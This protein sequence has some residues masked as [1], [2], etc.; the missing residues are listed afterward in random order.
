MPELT[1]TRP[2]APYAD[3][4]ARLAAAVEAARD[5]ILD[6]SHRIHADPEPAFEEHHAAA[7]V[8]EI[9]ARHGFAVEHPAGSLATA[10]RADAP[11]RAAAATARA[12]AS[13]PSTTRCRGSATAAATTRWPRRASGPP[14]RWPRSPTSSRARSSSSA[15]RPRSGGAASRS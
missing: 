12:S 13:S 1:A 9:L 11:R 7:W 3:D 4:K 15:R 2:A 5:E 6:L 10:I 8:A 14:S